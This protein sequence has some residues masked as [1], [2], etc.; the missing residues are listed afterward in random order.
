MP[1]KFEI[2]RAVQKGLDS[3]TVALHVDE[4]E[5]DKVWTKAVKTKLCEIGREFCRQSLRERR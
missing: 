5:G 3:L 1:G 2:M 4:V